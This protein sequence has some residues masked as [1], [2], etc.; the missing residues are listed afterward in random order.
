[1]TA[2]AVVSDRSLWAP[3]KGAQSRTKRL[4]CRKGTL[5]RFRRC[6]GCRIPPGTVGGPSRSAQSRFSGRNGSNLPAILYIGMVWSQTFPGPRSVARKSPSPPNR[7]LLRPLT[8][9]TL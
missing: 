4:S 1:M 6:L 5:V 7:M 2:L 8:M 9:R 3:K